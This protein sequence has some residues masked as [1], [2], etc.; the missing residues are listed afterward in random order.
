MSVLLRSD[1][2]CKNQTFGL[3]VELVSKG[4]ASGP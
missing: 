2:L 3:G 4:F 1:I